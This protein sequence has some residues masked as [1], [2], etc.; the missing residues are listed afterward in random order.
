MKVCD[1]CGT[2]ISYDSLQQVKFPYY[3]IYIKCYYTLYNNEEVDLC[4]NC[5]EKIVNFIT[6]TDKDGTI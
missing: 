1:R 5:K 3:N 2:A 4:D 6:N